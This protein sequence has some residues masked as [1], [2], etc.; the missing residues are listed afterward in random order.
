MSSHIRSKSRRGQSLLL[1]FLML[2]AIVGV[3]ALTLDFGFVIL[4]RRQMQTGV[5]PAAIEGLR[6]ID[7]DDDNV[8]D[9]R[10]SAKKLVQNVFDDDLDPRQNDTTVGAGI[11][12]SL[13]Q[14]SGYRKATLGSGTN[15]RTLFQ[16]RSQ[17]VFRPVPQLNE[18]NQ[19]HGDLVAGQYDVNSL[20]HEEFSD[21]SRADFSV[22]PN[23]GINNSFLVRL[24]RT[25]NPNDLDDILGV[26]SSD[27][28]LPLLIG[29][30]AWFSKQPADAAYA[31]RRDGVSVRATAIADAK[32]AVRVWPA[33]ENPQIYGAIPFGV[34]KSVFV[35]QTILDSSI[36]PTAGTLMRYGQ[37]ASIAA[38]GSY[39]G[40]VGYVAV[41]D[42]S[43]A[44]N[45]VIGF[46]LANASNIQDRQSNCSCRLQ[47]AWPVVGSLTTEQR[48]ALNVSRQE[49][50]ENSPNQ[51]LKCPALVR[52]IR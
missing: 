18:S 41:I 19:I 8:G 22:I 44:P 17:Y 11:S 9:G 10:A 38:S 42:D 31:I 52:S 47:D 28:G 15:S 13:V 29:R 26:S 6:N 23:A 39:S 33:S 50:A 36:L 25:H 24:R 51:L 40:E 14:G 5:N 35:S 7:L 20:S 32:F 45:R 37:V 2:V 48:I 4:A 30:L 21:Y 34:L 1:V 49:A 43:I 3:L 16:N 27:G 12:S 46:Y